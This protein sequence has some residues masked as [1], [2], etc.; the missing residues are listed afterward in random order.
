MLLLKAG[1]LGIG[2]QHLRARGAGRRTYLA[3][4]MTL[5]TAESLAMILPLP[6]P[7]GS[8]ERAVRFI[9]L[10]GDPGLFT[11]LAKGFPEPVAAGPGPLARSAP[12]AAPLAVVEVGKGSVPRILHDR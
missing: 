4:S 2:D 9:D 7:L 3:Y 5:A 11:D 10:S 6:V 1:D 8:P 12:K